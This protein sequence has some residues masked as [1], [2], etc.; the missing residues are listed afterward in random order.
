MR[1]WRIVFIAF[2]I[3]PSK[4]V[5]QET[6]AIEKAAV[7]IGDALGSLSRSTLSVG[8]I[9]SLF[10]FAADPT[11]STDEILK[12]RR[13]PEYARNRLEALLAAE[14]ADPGLQ[15]SVEQTLKTKGNMDYGASLR[16]LV[17]SL[18]S[19]PAAGNPP[20]WLFQSVALP[21]LKEDGSGEGLAS[22]QSEV[23]IRYPGRTSGDWIRDA[24]S[25]RDERQWLVVEWAD[26]TYPLSLISAPNVIT[27]PIISG[28]TNLNL[29]RFRK[30]HE[31]FLDDFDFDRKLSLARSKEPPSNGVLTGSAIYTSVHNLDGSEIITRFVFTTAKQLIGDARLVSANPRKEAEILAAELSQYPKGTR[32]LFYGDDLKSV[33]LNRIADQAGI[34]PLRRNPT[35]RKSLR[36]TQFRLEQLTQRSIED[37]TTIFV[38]GLPADAAAVQAYGPFTAAVDAWL[39][40]RRAV[41]SSTYGMFPNRINSLK[42]LIEEFQ[43]GQND[44]VYVV[45]HSDGPYLYVGPD[46]ISLEQLGHLPKRDA[47]SR[48]RARVAVL[49]ICNA[50]QISGAASSGLR[51][52][53]RKQA[54]SLSEVLVKLGYFDQV[55]APDHPIEGPEAIA[56]IVAQVRGRPIAEI[57]TLFKTWNKSVL[58]EWPQVFI[59]DVEKR[60][61]TRSSAAFN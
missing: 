30:V 21:S 6:L 44:V 54:Q 26:P 53:F 35:V 20:R 32:V 41:E 50:G 7:V 31:S 27:F 1:V 57:R 14:E 22:F 40:A 25:S 15:G 13:D 46:R 51:N 8:K 47:G 61:G 49:A 37:E 3:F 56:A 48:S 24:L 23:L 12:E 43:N 33:D 39:E 28:I 19:S 29:S 58:L 10:G 42:A 18:R 52:L 36:D 55:I 5:G 34:D 59:E 9:Y 11:N 4:I 2:V 17:E 60:S 45:A 38:N 16:R